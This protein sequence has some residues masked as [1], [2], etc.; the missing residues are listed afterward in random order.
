MHKWK[1]QQ[2][3]MLFKGL[4]YLLP[5]QDNQEKVKK[6]REKMGVTEERIRQ[7]A[8]MN[9]RS[10]QSKANVS[11]ANIELEREKANAAKANAKPGSMAA[12]ANL[13]KEFSEKN[14]RK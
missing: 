7:A 10:I 5:K 1:I 13:V 12:K 4:I 14:N 6:K 9:T 3:D 11:S 8:A 2:E